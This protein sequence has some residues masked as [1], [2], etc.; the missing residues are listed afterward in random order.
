M[1]GGGW[2]A[3]FSDL[4]RPGD[5]PGGHF[6]RSAVSTN[7]IDWTIESGIILGAGAPGALNQTATHPFAKAN[8][9]G[10][11]T[12]Y[13]QGE[14]ADAGAPNGNYLGIYRS[15]SV[16][17]RTF[18]Q[19]EKTGVARGGDPDVITLLNGTTMMYFGDVVTGVGGVI[20]VAR[21]N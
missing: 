14:R 6:I 13:Y 10:S 8:P 20:R 21:L 15:T 2:R 16:D 18:T 7:L 11:V 5:P 19:E 9:N 17:G 1:A 12:L 4:E 3:Y